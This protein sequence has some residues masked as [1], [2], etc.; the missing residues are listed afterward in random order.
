MLHS[1][2]FYRPVINTDGLVKYFYS[3]IYNFSPRDLPFRLGYA[4]CPGGHKIYYIINQLSRGR[5][6]KKMHSHQHT[7]S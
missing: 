6:H 2:I 1:D 3:S 7:Y 5:D 4:V